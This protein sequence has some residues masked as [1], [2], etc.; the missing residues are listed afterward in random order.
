MPKS[1][2]LFQARWLEDEWNG[3]IMGLG[4]KWHCCNSQLLL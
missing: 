3:S 4:K 2:C 1:N